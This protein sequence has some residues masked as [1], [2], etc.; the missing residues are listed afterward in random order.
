MLECILGF[1]VFAAL[2]NNQ[3]EF[4]LVMRH[5]AQRKSL[6]SK[7]ERR[8]WLVKPHRLARQSVVKLRDVSAV[9]HS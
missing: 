7:S 8:H 4:N 3:A 5:I 2:A 1:D 9:V 6:P